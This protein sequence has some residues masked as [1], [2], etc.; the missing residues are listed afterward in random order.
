MQTAAVSERVFSF[1]RT[2]VTQKENMKQKIEETGISEEKYH[3]RRKL[4]KKAG[5]DYILFR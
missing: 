4:F 2:R 1:K 5:N 3:F